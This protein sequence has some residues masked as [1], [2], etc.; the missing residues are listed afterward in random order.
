[1]RRYIYYFAIL[2]S[3]IELF[4]M[5]NTGLVSIFALFM[6]FAFGCGSKW[7]VFYIKFYI[8]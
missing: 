6:G 1:M 5:A 3:I 8:K 7:V 4:Y 2:S